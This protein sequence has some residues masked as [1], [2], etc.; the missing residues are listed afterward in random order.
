MCG[1]LVLHVRGERTGGMITRE[2]A[3]DHYSIQEGKLDVDFEHLKFKVKRVTYEDSLCQNI[4]MNREIRYKR[5]R[6]GQ[7][8]HYLA[9][10][11]T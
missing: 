5:D 3:K 6:Q 1:K 7:C 10:R 2:I 11:V 4:I 8:R 9:Y